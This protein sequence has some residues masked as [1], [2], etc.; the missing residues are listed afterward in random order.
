MEPENKLA[1]LSGL[2]V[3]TI[4]GLNDLEKELVEAVCEERWKDVKELVFRMVRK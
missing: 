1:Q 3:Q 2:D 4:Q